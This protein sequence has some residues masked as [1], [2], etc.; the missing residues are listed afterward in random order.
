MPPN[1]VIHIVTLVCHTIV[2][3]TIIIVAGVLSAN[4]Q[5]TV[6]VITFL[7]ALGGVTGAGLVI[8]GR[9]VPTQGVDRSDQ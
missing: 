8:N 6:A 5:L 3:V 9:K 4:G 7:T 1:A 2:L